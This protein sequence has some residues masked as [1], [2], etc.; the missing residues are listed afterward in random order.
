[1]KISS[2][3][4]K[5]IPPEMLVDITRLITAYYTETPDPAVST[6]RVA[7]GTSGHRGTAFNRSFNED[8]ILAITQALCLYRKQQGTDG[9]LFMGFDT[10]ALSFPAYTTALEVLAANEVEVIIAENNEYT[11]T[12]VLSHA[13]LTYN[14][15][16][17]TG[18][19]DGIV[20]TPSHNP[21]QDG[22]FKY[23][24]P[25]GGPAGTSV[26]QWIEKR[27]NEFLE[28][29]LN[30]VKRVP[31]A[32]ALSAATTHRR[33]YLSAYI[34]DL[35]NVVDME[36]IRSANIKMGVDPLGGAGVHYWGR[37]AER[38]G[39]TLT[40]VNEAIDPTFRFMTLDWDGQIR[41]DPSSVHVMQRLIGMRD[42]YD[43]SFACDPDHDRHGIVTRSTGLL[44]PN[45]YLSVAIFYLF[46]HR[47]KWPKEAGVGK[48]VVSTGMI[49]RIAAQ[50]GRKLYDMPVGFKWFV[51]GLA[52]GALG[53]AGEESAGASFVRLDGSVWTTDKDG[54]IPALLAAEITARMG[55]DPGELYQELTGE[56]GEPVYDR[57][58]APATP[59]QKELLTK[60][61]PQHV[62]ITEL[63]GEEIQKV[64]TQA[65][66]NGAPIG[67]VKVMTETGWFA[68]RPSGTERIYKIYAE[69]FRGPDQL[70]CI[71]EEAQTIVSDALAAAPARGNAHEI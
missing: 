27:A 55:R 38:Y 15:G 24:P 30:G 17:K 67:G 49:D 37:I 60:L 23:N 54:F 11:P 43:L 71:I 41:M 51:D 66:G 8:H 33:D 19:A 4:G 9:P 56:F 31:F 44:P 14:R 13:I 1:M 3:A 29:R 65:P 6:Q 68:A 70:R 26:T 42:G 59:D 61:S 18:L 63:A 46:Q 36:V 69:S 16:R 7:F 34:A 5:T 20:I 12:P 2:L 50:L 22:G 40:V 39:L 47:P 57:V 52:N 21:P 28:S 25:N 64:L 32:K 35:G 62:T 10:H 48:T 53:F 45:H 58:E